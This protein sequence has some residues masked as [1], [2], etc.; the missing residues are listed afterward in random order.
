MTLSQPIQDLSGSRHSCSFVTSNAHVRHAF[1]HS[2]SICP[3]NAG[4][5]C[6]LT[7]FFPACSPTLRSEPIAALSAPLPS[8]LIPRPNPRN[9]RST[10]TPT[11]YG[12]YRCQLQNRHAY[13]SFCHVTRLHCGTTTP[14]LGCAEPSSP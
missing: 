12:A 2:H 6:T 1:V 4:A 3:Q 10:G 9:S 8:S 7:H 14:L 11:L 5:R 13:E